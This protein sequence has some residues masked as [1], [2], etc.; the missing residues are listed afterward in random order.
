MTAGER[1]LAAARGA[2]GAPFRLHGRRVAE[3]LDCVGLAGLAYGCAVPSGYRMR[4]GTADGVAQAVEAAGLVRVE[5]MRAG[6]LL[7]V[8]S[9]PG[10]LHLAIA[11]EDGVIHADAGLRRVVE[12]P[13]P[14]PWPVVARWRPQEED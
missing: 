8:R 5:N 10:Q 3:G 12:R 4:S 14:V 9:G 13:G 6:D 2:V 1:A 11:S 7:L